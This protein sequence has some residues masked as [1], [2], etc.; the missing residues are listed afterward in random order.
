M[1]PPRIPHVAWRNGRPR[2]MPG[3]SLR[4]KGYAG[5]DLKHDDGTWFSAGEALD[6]SVAF[7]TSLKKQ[8]LATR[9]AGGKG[10]RAPVLMSRKVHIAPTIR[11]LM[12][13]YLDPAT[14]PHINELADATV[15]DYRKKA[16]AL[17]L[18]CPEAWNASTEALS[19]AIC[20]GMSDRMLVTAGKATAVGAM[21]ILAMAIKWARKRDIIKLASN[22]ATDLGV[23]APAPRLRV[24]TVQE[25]DC[26][27]ETADA[28]GRPEIGDMIMLAV[29]TGQ[30][31]A[32]RL[33]ATHFM[34]SNGRIHF[35][36]QKTEAAVSPRLVPDLKARLDAAAQRRKDAGKFELLPQLVVNEQRW[37]PLKADYYRHLYDDVRRAAAAKL[38]SVRTLRDQDFRDTTVTWLAR[39]GTL[40]QDICAITGHSYRS[41]DQIWKH[42]LALDTDMADRGLENMVRWHKQQIGRN[43]KQ[44]REDE[45]DQ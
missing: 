5:K 2:F 28:L 40:L 31:Q 35:R 19:E 8:R 9:Q 30:R 34:I 12:D 7:S 41:A 11:Q 15:D 1:K 10:H 21:R 37:E 27:V 18:H 32:D 45:F 39:A 6:W 33:K 42:Y 26:L 4:L 44:D 23:G 14:H 16:R 43:R 17:E 20:L 13:M 3:K 22:P 36:Q 25:I 29:W 24:A 38:P